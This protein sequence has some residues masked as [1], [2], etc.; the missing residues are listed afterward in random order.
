VVV[1]YLGRLLIALSGVTVSGVP[2][3]PT[4]CLLRAFQ[5]WSN[6]A[7][8]RYSRGL[9]GRWCGTTPTGT[10]LS[11]VA[12]SLTSFPPLAK[13][14]SFFLCGAP[15]VY[16]GDVASDSRAFYLREVYPQLLG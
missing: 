2:M 8:Q 11:M 3:P 4:R 7:A 10:I 12:A 14:V 1:N 5:G 16:D 13:S 6:I 15:H 9:I